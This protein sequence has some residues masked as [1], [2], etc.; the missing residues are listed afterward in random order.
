MLLTLATVLLAAA[1]ATTHSDTTFQ[2]PQGSRLNVV[3]FGGAIAVRP[4]SKNQVRVEATQEGQMRVVVGNEGTSYSVEAIP[5]RRA[6]SRVDYQITAPSW[7]SLDLEGVYSDLTVD[8]WKSD[9]L[10]STVQGLVRVKGG[11]G[12]I[13]LS[14]IA[15]PVFVTGA[16]GRLQVSS[17]NDTV[18]VSDA[19]GDVS[20]ESVTGD[21]YL[22]RI[23]GKMI[24]AETVRGNVRFSGWI[25]D[26][27]RYRFSSHGG[28]LD[29][30]LPVD[31]N[32]T[33]SVA[34]FRG[35]FE[36]SFPIEIRDRRGRKFSFTLGSG[37][38]TVDL[39]TFEGMIR[40]SRAG[41]KDKPKE[42]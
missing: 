39:E 31:P 4:W 16:R 2:V 30:A 19:I 5:L 33:I 35:G 8:D 34:T 28:N 13:K 22:D 10:A 26:A 42:R 20:V 25:Q 15:G 17:V 9:V 27:G 18:F 6:P 40:L 32:A 41:A 21:V 11:E 38:A 29:V 23:R 14:S 1:A 36:S 12:L 24:E 3:N 37:G 7:M